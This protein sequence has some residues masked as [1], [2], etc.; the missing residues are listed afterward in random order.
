MRNARQA[1]VPASI[2]SDRSKLE[3]EYKQVMQL[4]EDA[5]LAEDPVK[6]EAAKARVMKAVT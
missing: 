5:L 6:R 2:E 4:V 1:G 3:A